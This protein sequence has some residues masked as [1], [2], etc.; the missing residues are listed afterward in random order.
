MRKNPQKDAETRRETDDLWLIFY[1][2]QT[3]RITLLYIL[4][5]P[6]L[7]RENDSWFG[8]LNEWLSVPAR[9]LLR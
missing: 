2:I 9:C 7:Q 8:L 1:L 5:L 3:R 6:T 4:D